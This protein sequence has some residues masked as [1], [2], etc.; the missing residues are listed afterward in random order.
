MVALGIGVQQ[1]GF[2]GVNARIGHWALD[3]LSTCIPAPGILDGSHVKFTGK[4]KSSGLRTAGG[5]P[6][7]SGWLMMDYYDQPGG[8][9]PLLVE[10]NMTRK[11]SVI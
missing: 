10:F 1:V 4:T 11:M 8:I 7:V 6:F 9:I 2:V 5:A 3:T